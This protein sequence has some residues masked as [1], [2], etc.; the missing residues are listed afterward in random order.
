MEM[1]DRDF[2]QRQEAEALKAQIR[3]IREELTRRTAAPTVIITDFPAGSLGARYGSIGQRFN[4]V[5]KP[6]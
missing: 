2:V 3:Q 1:D 6:E 5:A 4:Q